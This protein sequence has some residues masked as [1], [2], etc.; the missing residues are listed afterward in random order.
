MP[1][2]TPC[3]WCWLREAPRAMSLCP[4]CQKWLEERQ[5]DMPDALEHGLKTPT[6]ED[7][8]AYKSLIHHS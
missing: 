2:Q 6:T 5:A 3:L 7:S 8:L 1:H 4:R